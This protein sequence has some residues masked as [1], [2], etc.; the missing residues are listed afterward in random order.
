[1][2]KLVSLERP[3]EDEER[4]RREECRYQRDSYTIGRS[5]LQ[6]GINDQPT[7]KSIQLGTMGRLAEM[8]QF[9][10]YKPGCP[11]VRCRLREFLLMHAECPQLSAWADGGYPPGSA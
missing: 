4:E 1:M 5:A 11:I 6:S 7:T 2:K 9:L 8:R 3:S 10:R